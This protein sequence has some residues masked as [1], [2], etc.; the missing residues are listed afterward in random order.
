MQVV[1]LTFSIKETGFGK[2]GTK[3]RRRI[4]KKLNASCSLNTFWM[5][6]EVKWKH[7]FLNNHW[8]ISMHC[9]RYIC[10]TFN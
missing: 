1:I 4:L 6:M 10:D 5:D 8:I 3:L 2:S 7:C 9:P